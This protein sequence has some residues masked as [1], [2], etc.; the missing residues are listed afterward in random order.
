MKTPA[1]TSLKPISAQASV[2]SPPRLDFN[3]ARIRSTDHVL[4]TG[5]KG[6]YAVE[7]TFGPSH[8]VTLNV[9]HDGKVSAFHRFFDPDRDLGGIAASQPSRVARTTLDANEKAALA[10]ALEPLHAQAEVATVLTRLG[11]APKDPIRNQQRL[12]GELTKGAEA[13]VRQADLYGTEP[14]LSANPTWLGRAREVLGFQF[15]HGLQKAQGE[16]VLQQKNGEWVDAQGIAY[17]FLT[18]DEGDA[19]GATATFPDGSTKTFFYFERGAPPYEPGDPANTLSPRPLAFDPKTRRA[20]SGTKLWTDRADQVARQLMRDAQGAVKGGLVT[21]DASSETPFV[22]RD[23]IRY[24]VL[25]VDE[26]DVLGVRA[27]F[28]DGSEKTS[29]Q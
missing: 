29:L 21:F 15:T 22:D 26:G 10:R 1:V 14:V 18:A 6:P 24:E 9:D 5:A 17:T 12:S 4:G 16:G 11:F 28:P 20:D 7:A 19:E 3:T 13:H 23:G 25:T 8:E 27:V 2:D